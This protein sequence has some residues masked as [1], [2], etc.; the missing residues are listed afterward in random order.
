MLAM[1]EHATEAI[2]LLKDAS[3]SVPADAAL[4]ISTGETAD[5]STPL[6]LAFVD[7]P[8]AADEVVE[9]G[10]ERVFLEPAAAQLLDDKV[11]DARIE[12]GRVDFAVGEQASADGRADI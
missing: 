10:G 2:R 5:E 12:A 7:A 8:E 3:D 1:T 11:L 9:A 4:R 6:V